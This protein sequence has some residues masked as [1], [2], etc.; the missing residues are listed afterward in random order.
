MK[1]YRSLLLGLLLMV[2]QVLA[3]EA[4]PAEE[5]PAAAGV[6]AV[7][8]VEPSVVEP[9]LPPVAPE[10]V[11]A[12]AK[13]LL[14]RWNDRGLDEL[15]AADFPQRDRLL[16]AFPNRVPPG[17]RLRLL[18]VGAIQTL[19]QQRIEAGVVST[20]SA[21]INAQ[22]EYDDPERGFQRHQGSAEYLFRITRRAPR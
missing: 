10:L 9:P 11:E 17:A 8:V 16:D 1:R 7:D 2:P 5:A 15:L 12:L 4:G 21:V 13:D 19:E 6:A 18:S 14:R 22:L 20:V 3:D